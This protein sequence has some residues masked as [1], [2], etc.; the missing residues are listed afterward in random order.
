[1]P[2]AV[3]PSVTVV[4]ASHRPE[5]IGALAR[6][7]SGTGGRAEVIVV[8]DYA[9]EDLAGAF[10]DITWIHH[11][12]K[13]I[14]AKR[15]AGAK[16]ATAALLAFTD[17]DCVPQPGWAEAGVRYL[18]RHPDAGAVE[19]KTVVDSDG[20][21]AAPLAEFKRLERR[22][23]RTNNIFYRKEVFL[24]AGGFDE[25]FTVQREDVDL[26]FTVLSTGHSI[27][28]CEDAVVRH[29]VRQGEQWDLLKNCVN[30]R[31]DPLLYKKHPGLYRKHIGS[32]FTPSIGLQL[33]IHAIAILA[34]IFLPVVGVAVLGAD[35][36]FALALAV[37]RTT[38]G[39]GGPLWMLRDWLSFFAA[40]FV[41]TGALIYGSA[42]FGKLMIV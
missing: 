39:R 31:F 18:E 30:R 36:V 19:G 11:G 29:G 10:P 28:Y 17:D 34:L 21:N 33:A 7:F 1:M 3:K 4:V 27:G 23:F 35:A 14:S 15:N 2:R 41:I 12:E 42:K 13:S 25:R 9:V 37:R 24:G 6:V 20:R 22:G 32:P 38:R 8:A 40:P 5:Y 16:A 26:A